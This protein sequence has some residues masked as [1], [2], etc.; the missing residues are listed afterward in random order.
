M[1]ALVVRV[2]SDKDIARMRVAVN[3]P[4]HKNLFGEG[5]D[6]VMHDLLLTKV[7]RIHLLIISDFE[8]IDPLRHHHTLRSVL[9]VNSWNIQFLSFFIVKHVL[10]C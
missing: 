4:R 2:G 10:S 1:L 8:P 6:K 9:R 3:E 5:P 7:M